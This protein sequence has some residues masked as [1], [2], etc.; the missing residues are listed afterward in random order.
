[1]VSSD[2]R[3]TARSLHSGK[4]LIKSSKNSKKWALNVFRIVDLSDIYLNGGD[5]LRLVIWKAR[6][7][8][9]YS[10]IIIMNLTTLIR[11][12]I[13]W[14]VG[15]V[16]VCF[17]VILFIIKYKPTIF[18]G[19]SGLNNSNFQYDISGAFITQQDV[20]LLYSTSGGLGN[21]PSNAM[22][23]A[24]NQKINNIQTLIAQINSMVP[25][26]IQDIIPGTI[27]STQD[28]TTVGINIVNQP[29]TDSCGNLLGKW[30]I[31]AV[32]PQSVDGVQG[33]Q[34][35]KG[36]QGPPGPPG[37]PGIRGDRGPWGGAG[38]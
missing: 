13:F 38:L 23:D 24:I 4:I 31:N 20:N 35:P 29:Y 2:F 15:F 9:F 37:P 8:I 6:V 36:L 11:K 21:L 17:L 3:A 27:T 19:L 7:Y 30:V 26:T 25:G 22:L 5:W 10:Y 12:N 28:L 14:I 1:M 33:P 18:E 34:G 16:V 32:L